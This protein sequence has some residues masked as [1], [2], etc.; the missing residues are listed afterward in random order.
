M[1]TLKGV[2]LKGSRST[3]VSAK[4]VLP[5]RLSRR[6]EV[7]PYFTSTPPAR[8]NFGFWPL[9]LSYVASPYGLTM[10]SR[11]LPISVIPDSSPACETL[12][13]PNLLQYAL[14]RSCSFFL[15]MKRLKFRPQ[16]TCLDW[17]KFN[18]EKGI[19]IVAVHPLEV[20]RASEVHTPS[21]PGSKSVPSW[22]LRSSTMSPSI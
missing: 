2:M 12:V 10:N 18:V 14:H 20:M 3:S 8:G 22:E 13:I 5:V 11:P 19:S 16:R 17:V 7:M 21:Q 4:S 1:K 15:R 9:S 6:F